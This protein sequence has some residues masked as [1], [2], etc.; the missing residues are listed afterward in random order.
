[1]KTFR[2]FK[3]FYLCDDCPNEWST[4]MPVVAADYCPCCDREADPYDSDALLED[5]DAEEDA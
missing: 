2:I 3:N 4:E 5:V 1:M